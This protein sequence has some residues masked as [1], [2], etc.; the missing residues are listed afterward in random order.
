LLREAR[1]LLADRPE[2]DRARFER[3]LRR[4]ER[5]YPIRED[6]ASM[7]WS[8]QAGLIRRVAVEIGRRLGE[9]SI[10]DDP[11]DV[12]FLEQQEAFDALLVRAGGTAPACRELVARRRAERVWVEAHPGPLVYGPQS[13][14]RA[15][16]DQL[17]AEVRLVTEAQL[18]KVE[19]AGHFVATPPQ[20]GG[21]RLTGVPASGGRCTGTVRVLLSEADFHKLRPGD[22]L[23]CPITSPAWSVL[24]PNVAALVADTGG[25]MAHSAII[26][27][28]FHIPAV[29]ATG[30]ATP[31]LRDGQRVTV[32]GTAGSVE[33]LA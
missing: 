8:D 10:L 1:T 25:V 11:D 32:D 28:E 29:V 13:D 6:K 24:F 23:V 7:T 15:G 33:V 12:F 27:R 9:R 14:P 19:R 31:L 3:A 4:A 20:P 17:P 30:N 16:L 2:A 5:W 18:W 22:V 21:L 26:A